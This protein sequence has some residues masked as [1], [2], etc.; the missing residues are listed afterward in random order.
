M[1]PAGLKAIALVAVPLAVFGVS[2]VG[3]SVPGGALALEKPAAAIPAATVRTTKAPRRLARENWSAPQAAF[4]DA[5]ARTMGSSMV[6]RLM[7][8]RGDETCGCMVGK[9]EGVGAQRDDA[10]LH[11]LAADALDLTLDKALAGENPSQRQISALLLKK[12]P[13][14]RRQATWIQGAVF[15]AFAR[16][17]EE[18]ER[19]GPKVD[20]LRALFRG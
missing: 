15:H 5:C 11:A 2:Q 14:M 7:T 1:I 13:G 3:K 4:R 20:A 6:L 12:Y 19:L 16:C 8:I 18:D 17:I 9:L 10:A